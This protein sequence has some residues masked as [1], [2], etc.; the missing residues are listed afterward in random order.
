MS[1]CMKPE[2]QVFETNCAL[3]IKI[4]NEAELT[5]Q[6]RAR[7]T[8]GR[9]ACERRVFAMRSASARLSS[10]PSRRRVVICSITYQ[11]MTLV[12]RIWA[13][14]THICVQC[15]VDAYSVAHASRVCGFRCCHGR[16]VRHSCEFGLQSQRQLVSLAV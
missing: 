6:A 11:Y 2:D 4:C 9:S 1:T 7:K 16:L 5:I 10:V 15:L 3:R 12:L 8:S 13:V 14:L